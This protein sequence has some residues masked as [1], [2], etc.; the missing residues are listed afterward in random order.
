MKHL[1]FVGAVLIGLALGGPVRADD[2]QQPAA[3]PPAP[4]VPAAPAPTDS[5]SPHASIQIDLGPKTSSQQESKEATK[6][7]NDKLANA[8]NKILSKHSD[9]SDEDRKE[10]VD[11]L[12]H[13]GPITINASGHPNS[14][15]TIG[16]MAVAALAIIFV[17]GSPIMIVAAVLYWAYRRR[18]LT[19]ETIK[20]YL[21]SGKEIPPEVMESMFSERKPKNNLQKGLILSGTGL[22]IFIAFMTIDAKFVASLGLIPLFIGAAQLLIWKLEKGDNS[23]KREGTGAG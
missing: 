12:R 2:T 19:H 4:P 11:S 18:R 5:E 8:V 13:M 21:A 15:N 3:S 14:E 23:G 7:A 6:E 10:V 1:N 17:F 20:Q 9:M 22:G 16:E